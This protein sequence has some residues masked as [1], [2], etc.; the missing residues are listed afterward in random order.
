MD[1]MDT[2]EE[3]LKA[4]KNS[5]GQFQVNLNS[6]GEA[7][8]PRITMI[9][10]NPRYWYFAILCCAY[11]DPLNTSS[12]INRCQ[13]PGALLNLQYN[14]HMLNN[15]TNWSR[16]DWEFGFDE[17]GLAAM[18]TAYLAIYILYLF[19]HGYG[20]KELRFIN[21]SIH[22]FISAFTAVTAIQLL[23]IVLCMI[24]W[25]SY[26]QDG[27]GE[28]VLNDVGKVLNVLARI[29]F[30][31]LLMFLAEGWTIS[32]ISLTQ[33]SKRTIIGALS[34]ITLVY[35]ALL[36]WGFFVRTPE[37]ITPPRVQQVLIYILTAVWILFALWFTYTCFKSFMSMNPN[38]D[39]QRPK[40]NLFLFLGVLY[41]LWV[42]SLPVIDFVSLADGVLQP[43]E[44]MRVTTTANLT[45]D[46][47]AYF[48][49]TGIVWPSHA[50]KY[51]QAPTRTIGGTLT[52]PE[53]DYRRL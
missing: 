28:P 30:M 25:T 15:E 46:T 44:F 53:D 13:T 35:A 52:M 22:S 24:H 6:N 51:F 14:I 27:T 20:L 23:S 12:N 42:V 50:S 32:K 26:G 31:V 45:I 49:F 43:W 4:S 18:Y 16:N 29:I 17:K 36:L 33:N 10:G 21:G 2:C 3:R 40:R 8:P 38:D 39:S 19:V 34:L 9:Q 41:G 1:N 37:M 48:I 11:Q 7:N 5:P 47:L